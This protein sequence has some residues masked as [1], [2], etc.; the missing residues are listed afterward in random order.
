[1]RF[2]SKHFYF[3]PLLGLI[4][5]TST[6][7]NEPTFKV[8]AR[9][10]YDMTQTTAND[11]TTDDAS[12][13][14]TWSTVKGSHGNWRTLGR[15]D[16]S[17]KAFKKNKNVVD[18]ALSYTGF[19]N[20]V[21]TLGRQKTVYGL[22]WESGNMAFN[23]AERTAT[24]EYFTF[25][26]M[27]GVMAD[28]TLSPSV[29]LMLGQ[30]YRNQRHLTSARITKTWQ[31]S[32]SDYLHAGLG[33]AKASESDNGVIEL[34]A[35]IGRLH[36]QFEYFTRSGDMG[37]RDGGYLEAGWFLTQDYRPYNRGVFGRVKP[38]SGNQ[39]WQLVARYEHGTGDFSDLGINQ[40]D[41]KQAEGRN[42]GVGV[43][44]YYKQRYAVMLSMI[45]GTTDQA[46]PEQA[47]LQG[48]ELRLRLQM[49]I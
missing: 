34:A 32:P 30:Y 9:A 5:G 3:L 21:V 42:Y 31:S 29:R 8:T 10:Q 36:G 14:R 49:A 35:G 2:F 22:N 26:R 43:N 28:I 17:E 40:S 47:W 48:S 41:R 45:K 37:T 12:F 24:T 6:F 23:F 19:D 44:W 7:A 27:D 11:V 38:Q 46:L 16:L 25:N 18:F 4:S 1:M 13:R 33:L 39:S 15:F 20:T